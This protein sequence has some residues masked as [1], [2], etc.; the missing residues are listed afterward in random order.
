MPGQDKPG[1]ESTLTVL[2]AL[3]ANLAIA[4]LKAIAGLLTASASILAEAGHSVA[5][6]VTE[7]FLLTAL[8]RSERP[9]DQRHP[10]GYGKERYFWSLIAAIGIFLSGAVFA[11]VEGVHALTAPDR[12]EPDPIIGYAVLALGFVIECVSWV[13]A[14]RQVRS[15]ATEHGTT[16][17]YYLRVSDDP[18]VKTVLLEDTAA[19]I[20]LMLA[21]AGVGLHQLTGQ[22]LWDGLASFLIGLLL[23]GVAYVMGL[24]NLSLLIGQQA[25]GQL[26][27]ALSARLGEEPEV[28]AVVDLLTM[29][30]GTDRVLLCA[31][32]DFAEGLT[33]TDVEE[34][35]VRIE[36]GLRTAFPKLHEVFLVPVPRSDPA[37][38]ARIL[39]RYGHAPTC[40]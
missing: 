38:R 23:A 12:Q 8:R 10:F 35:V 32:I 36:A 9:A 34:A 1:S 33:S 28:D 6:T 5:D 26:L 4:V 37:L 2:V 7:I 20:G 29:S 19:L 16:V 30:T 17:R 18:T 27:E 14:W 40:P 21:F 25:D 15:E 13:K 22:A 11:F 39:A 31:R 24:A 3:G